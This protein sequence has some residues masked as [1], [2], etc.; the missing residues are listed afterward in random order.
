MHITISANITFFPTFT[1]VL[2]LWYIEIL[3]CFIEF[4]M[5]ISCL[6]NFSTV[7]SS[8]RNIHITINA[9]I[10]FLQTFTRV[11][12]PWYIV[13]LFCFIKFHMI[14]SCLHNFSTNLSI[15]RQIHITIMQASP[16]SKPFQRF[17][18]LCIQPRIA[19]NVSS[20]VAAGLA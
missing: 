5:N 15:F 2:T 3:T 18:C 6:H 14:I 12:A 17:S 8:F 7:L 1:R 19:S 16:F 20:L 13:I 10:T 11:F 4:H 9:S